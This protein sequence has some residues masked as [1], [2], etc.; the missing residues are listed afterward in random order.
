M[1]RH[2]NNRN[3]TVTQSLTNPN[4][5]TG[6]SNTLSG[7][8]TLGQNISTQSDDIMF[9]VV[10]GNLT[11]LRRL[12]TQTNINE[13][14]D[15][16]NGYTALHHAVR[17]KKNDQVVEFLLSMGADPALKSGEQKDSIDLAIESN[18]RYLIDKMINDKDVELDN[19]NAKLSNVDYKFKQFERENKTLT[20]ENQ[21]LKKSTEQYVNKIEELKVENTNLKRKYEDSEKA[22][23]NLLKKTKKN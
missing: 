16:K 1:F 5:F 8:N 22:F 13:I 18:Y 23:S 9:A 15:R 4:S 14:I 11:T 2:N 20:E 3:Q 21:Y 7:S 19:L 12:I 10:T 6:S 17:I